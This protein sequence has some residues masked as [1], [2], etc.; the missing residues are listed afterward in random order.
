[1]FVAGPASGGDAPT[2]AATTENASGIQQTRTIT[3]SGTVL[4]AKP[5][6][7]GDPAVGQPAPSVSGSTFG[8]VEMTLPPK[9]T[10]ALLVFMAHWCPHCQREVPLMAAWDAEGNFPDG[11]DVFAVSTSVN[12]PRGNFPPSD[13]FDREAFPF[14]VMA[15]SLDSEAAA[16]F[17]VDGF[18]AFVMVDAEGKIA[19]RASGE[20]AMEQLTEWMQATV[21]GQAI[22]VT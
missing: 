5:V 18:P 6:S 14:A 17:G 1:M 7:G 12:E 4:D 20:I 11:A 2:E 16:A 9:G 19:W 22:T 3:V 13:W 10:P 15:D 8:G 21:D